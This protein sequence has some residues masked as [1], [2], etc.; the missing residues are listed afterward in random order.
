MFLPKGR[1]QHVLQ[2]RGKGKWA[3]DGA[4]VNNIKRTFDA[5][6]KKA[7]VSRSTLHDLRRSCITNWARE[8]PAHVVQKLADHSDIKTTQKYYLIVRQEDMDKARL[9][10]S[11]ILERRPTDPL[12]THSGP[13]E[14]SCGSNEKSWQ[15]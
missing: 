11:K 8:L 10:N 14:P 7:G 15:P 12:L 2:R 4:L 6:L 1:W 5:L 3:E 9:V 13:N